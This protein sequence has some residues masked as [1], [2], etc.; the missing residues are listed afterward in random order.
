MDVTVNGRVVIKIDE[1]V[2]KHAFSIYPEENSL[3]RPLL[4]EAISTGEI[5]FT[6]LRSESDKVFVPWQMF[7]LNKKGFESNLKVIEDKRYKRIPR[8]LF[9]NK[10]TSGKKKITSRRIIDRLITVHEIYT[11]TLTMIHPFNDS[12]LGMSNKAAAAHTAQYFDIDLS[13]LHTRYTRIESAFDYLAGCLLDKKITVSRGMLANNLLP[14]WQVTDNNLYK[15]TSGFVIKD[16]KSPLIFLPYQTNPDE[17]IGRQIYTMFFLLV[18]VGLGEYEFLLHTDL[19]SKTLDKA[20][21]KEKKIHEIVGLI[22]FPLEESNKINGLDETILE[23][24]SRKIKMTPSAVLTILLKRGRIT[25]PTYNKLKKKNSEKKR[26]PAGFMQT[27]KITTSLS[28]LYSKPGY[29]SVLN[30]S[31]LTPIQKQRTLFG[32]VNQSQYK[33]VL[34]LISKL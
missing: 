11:N 3:E 5:S 21:T 31:T 32:K 18:C 10:R 19:T 16:E 4:R 25:I 14:N 8:S 20:S 17:A 22:L 15:N 27:P 12:L 26:S 28:K 1:Y 24:L 30:N 33:D 2:F 13:R 29:M 7:L 34:N 9:A 6:D 23:E